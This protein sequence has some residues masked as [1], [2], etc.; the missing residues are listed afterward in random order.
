MSASTARS[1]GQKGAALTPEQRRE[2]ERNLARLL[3]I[4]KRQSVAAALEE[5]DRM[6]AAKQGPQLAVRGTER[7]AGK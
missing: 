2:G 7:T 5:W 1:T 3:V 4:A 6:L